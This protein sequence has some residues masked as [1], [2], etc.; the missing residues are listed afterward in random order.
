MESLELAK[1]VAKALYGKKALDLKVLKVEDL[2]VL[3]DYFVIASGS[4]TTHVGALADEVDY[5]LSQQ[6]IEP[7]RKEGADS[8]NWILMDYSGVV[9]H[10]FYPEMREYYALE[11]LWA[12]A[13]PVEL[14]LEEENADA[15]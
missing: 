7:T 14:N 10:V 8:K 2:T 12:D 13:K 15:L 6:G 4:S 9:V 1:Q 3:T 5:R 11:H